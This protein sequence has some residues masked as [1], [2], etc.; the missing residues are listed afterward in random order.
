MPTRL[1]PAD[2]LRLTDEGANG[3]LDGR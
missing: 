1:R 2:L 3:V